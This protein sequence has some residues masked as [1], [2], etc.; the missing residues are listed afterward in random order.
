MKLFICI[1]K[2][3]KTFLFFNNDKSR[4]E[5]IKYYQ[6]NT[7]QFNL[8]TWVED[9][10]ED[11]SGIYFVPNGTIFYPGGGGQPIDHGQIKL[12]GIYYTILRVRV[13]GDEIRH[14]IP[15][16]VPL[17]KGKAL[18][19]IIEK[20]KRIYHSK[21]HTAGHLVASI[22]SESIEESLVPIKGYHYPDNPYVEFEAKN[23]QTD[24]SIVHIINDLISKSI[25]QKSNVISRW[26]SID[27]MKNGFVPK[28]FFLYENHQVIRWITIEGF[29]SYPC[30]GT[31]IS[32][33]SELNQV[34]VS[35][36]KSKRNVLRVKYEI[37]KF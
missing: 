22:I 34:I 18:L 5:T 30:G 28:N 20:N 23:W 6:A 26:E 32:N 1:H 33:L 25:R 29:K 24:K 16:N 36:I 7:Y 13:V 8:M 37:S 31:H 15:K 27:K 4:M 12:E 35:K 10:G 14:Y 9:I 21:I 11:E 3:G 17:K 2:K 19:L